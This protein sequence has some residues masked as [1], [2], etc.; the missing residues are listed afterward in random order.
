M[1]IYCTQ[2][3]AKHS[4]GHMFPGSSITS[5]QKKTWFTTESNSASVSQCP[6][7][8]YM[9]P[10]NTYT[11]LYV[12]EN[13]SNIRTVWPNYALVKPVTHCLGDFLQQQWLQQWLLDYVDE[14]DGHTDL[15]LSGDTWPTTSREIFSWS[16]LIFNLCQGVKMCSGEL[17][18]AVRLQLEIVQPDDGIWRC[19]V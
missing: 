8:Q 18:M 19:Y 15:G 6:D 9:T 4:F 7:P 14:T 5:L 13:W 17:W 16:S 1:S 11:S 12:G 3:G 2:A 10:T